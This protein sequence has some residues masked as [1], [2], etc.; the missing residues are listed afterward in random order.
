MSVQ[1]LIF[2]KKNAFIVW[3]FSPTAL[4]LPSQWEK[5]KALV[6]YLQM[7]LRLNQKD[8]SQF[9]DITAISF[10]L[11][12]WRVSH[13]TCRHGSLLKWN[14]SSTSVLNYIFKV[15]YSVKKLKPHKK[16]LNEKRKSHA[17]LSISSPS[18]RVMYL[19]ECLFEYLSMYMTHELCTH[20]VLYSWDT[21]IC[22]FFF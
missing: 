11:F 12:S 16:I 14:L 13:T 10:R 19:P 8:T 18:H 21:I 5:R 2:F 17:P 4:I 6:N 3:I 9:P 15:T 7:P 22:V 1:I 20:C